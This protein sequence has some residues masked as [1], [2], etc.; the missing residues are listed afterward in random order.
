ML[1]QTNISRVGLL[2]DWTCRKMRGAPS[3]TD[4]YDGIDR[5]DK[6]NFKNVLRPS[7][8]GEGVP[9]VMGGRSYKARSRQEGGGG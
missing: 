7:L 2:Q 3:P 8:A 1:G 5:P 9:G 4:T 6:I